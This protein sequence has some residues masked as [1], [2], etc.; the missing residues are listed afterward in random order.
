M[1]LYAVFAA[2]L[3]GLMVFHALSSLVDI[4]F[5]DKLYESGDPRLLAGALSKVLMDLFAGLLFGLLG[6]GPTLFVLKNR[7]ERPEWFV[8]FSKYFAWALVVFI[9]IGTILGVLIFRFLRP[10][11]VDIEVATETE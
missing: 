9:P 10:V 3:Y 8:D 5:I 6:T 2:L 7:N 11:N 4:L 1:A